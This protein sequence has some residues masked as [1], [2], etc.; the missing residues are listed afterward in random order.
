MNWFKTE[1][2]RGHPVIL[3]TVYTE[4]EHFDCDETLVEI[5]ARYVVCGHCSGSGR[6]SAHLGSF[7][8]DEWAQ[9]SVEFREDYLNGLYDQVC[10]ECGGKRVVAIP[11]PMED[12]ASE[13]DREK[14]RLFEAECRERAEYEAMCAAE[15]RMGA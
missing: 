11:I 15:R 14:L 4:T 3:F 1:E 5:P 13:K 7:T 9:E 8:A 12:L 2:R 10:P 6:S